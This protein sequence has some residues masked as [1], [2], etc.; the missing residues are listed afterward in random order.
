[1]IDVSKM[2]IEAFSAVL[3]SCIGLS[4]NKLADEMSNNGMPIGSVAEE[5]LKEKE[6]REDRSDGKSDGFDKNNTEEIITLHDTA[7][8]LKYQNVLSLEWLENYTNRE[9]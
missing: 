4:S 8:A 9:I 2:S 3:K 5:W 7:D 6:E 1:M